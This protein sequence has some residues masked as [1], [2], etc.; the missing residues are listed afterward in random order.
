[1]IK[2]YKGYI[3]SLFGYFMSNLVWYRLFSPTSCVVFWAWFLAE[4]SGGTHHHL[5]GLQSIRRRTR[6]SLEDQ[7]PSRTGD[8]STAGQLRG[9]E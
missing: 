8:A 2:I 4:V 6:W 9:S 3:I 1:M 7:A 5:A